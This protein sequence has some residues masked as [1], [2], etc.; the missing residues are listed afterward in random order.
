MRKWVKMLTLI[1]SVLMMGSWPE[2][3]IDPA[4]SGTVTLTIM[5]GLGSFT[6][7]YVYVSPSVS[8]SWPSDRLLPRNV[9][10]PGESGTLVLSTGTYDIQ[11]VDE[12]GDEYF[13]W[14]LKLN[15]DYRIDGQTLRFI[16]ID[17][18]DLLLKRSKTV[19]S[20]TS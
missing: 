20:L 8:Y 18:H 2:V 1:I 6:I 16:L 5:N 7:D 3:M 9:L 11:N 15:S 12:D 4:S 10:R 13:R 19:F 17:V 14:D